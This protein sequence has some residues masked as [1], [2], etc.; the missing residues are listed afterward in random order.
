MGVGVSEI[1]EEHRIRFGAV[2]WPNLQL[3]AVTKLSLYTILKKKSYFACRHSVT[4]QSSAV[5][6]G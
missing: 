5:K 1:L 2:S 6:L 3:G 4:S